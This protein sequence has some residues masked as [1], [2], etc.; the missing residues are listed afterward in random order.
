MKIR[1]HRN[2]D[3]S[4]VE[5]EGDGEFVKRGHG[6]MTDEKT[7]ALIKC[8]KCGLENYAMNVLSGKCSWCPFD[9]N[10]IDFE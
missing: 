8:P 6:F 1:V 9:A 3:I 4:F 5:E 7:V 2:N 10:K